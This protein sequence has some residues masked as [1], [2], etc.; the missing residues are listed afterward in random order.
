MGVAGA[1]CT[2]F[3]MLRLFTLAFLAS[4]RDAHA[5]EHAH[6]SP[7]TMTVPLV[8]LAIGALG[9]VAFGWPTAFG[10]SFRIEAFLEPSV[11]YG[12]TATEAVV[13]HGGSPALLAAIST[14]LALGFAWWGWSSYKGGLEWRGPR[15]EV[16][17]PPPPAGEQVLRG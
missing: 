11:S 5:H 7:V 14:V 13:H 3:Y 15:R 8:V 4:A 2:A 17:L 12:V 16:A 6:E 10:G 9:A 1:C